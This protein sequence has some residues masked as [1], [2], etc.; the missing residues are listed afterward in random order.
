MRSLVALHIAE[1]NVDLAEQLLTD[2]GSLTTEDYFL[3]AQICTHRRQHRCAADALIQAS[4]NEGLA[5]SSEGFGAAEFST[6]EDTIHDQIWSALTRARRGPDAFT[7]RYHLAWW[8]LQQAIRNASSPIQQIE[9]WQKWKRANPSHPATIR[10]PRALTQLENYQAPNIAVLLPLSGR[11]ATAGKAV[12]DAFAAS[13]LAARQDN[14]TTVR[15]Y[16]TE[17][18]ALGQLWE[19]VLNDGANV[20]VGPLLKERAED[21][22]KLTESS[23]VPRL[24]LNYIEQAN[25]RSDSIDQTPALSSTPLFQLGIA[26]EDEAT[27]LVQFVLMEGIERVAIVH[28]DAA[29]ASRAVESYASNWAY[30]VTTAR[31][32]EVKELTRAVGEAMLVADSEARKTELANI[33]GEQLEFLPRAR[34]DLE[35]I[36]ALTNNVESRALVPALRFHFGDHL[37]V[38]ATSQAARRGDLK[39]LT[40]FYLSEM[41]LFAEHD[42]FTDLRES[43]SLQGNPLAELYALGHDA[44]QVAA[45]LPALDPNSAAALAGASGYLWLDKDGVFRR[46]LSLTKVTAS[47]TLEPVF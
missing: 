29:W 6:S 9:A 4:L 34:Q 39:A 5:D 16:D 37:P 30:P 40:N 19:Q 38:Y 23:D 27:S 22:A 13:Y 21:F 8:Q 45:W 35:A 26:I 11:L 17:S 7:H 18:A 15:F 36:V 46:E 10:P 32:S 28:G 44:Y 43:F 42:K 47:G 14:S 1:G 20:V 31:F 3:L 41:P 24:T 12:Q 33:I 25:P 2:T